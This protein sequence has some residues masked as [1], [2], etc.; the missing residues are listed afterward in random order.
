M[1]ILKKM[2]WK[3]VRR[4]ISA[5]TVI[6]KRQQVFF[7]LGP[8]CL[9][10]NNVNSFPSRPFTTSIK[11]SQVLC[12]GAWWGAAGSHTDV[13][14]FAECG[15]Q[16]ELPVTAPTCRAGGMEVAAVE[17]SRQ[18][19]LSASH[20]LPPENDVT[21][22]SPRV[23]TKPTSLTRRPHTEKEKGQTIMNSV[24]YSQLISTLDQTASLK[25]TLFMTVPAL[26]SRLQLF[27][28]SLPFHL[29]LN[30]IMTQK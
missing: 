8:I 6:F 5:Q 19:R 7:L 2:L 28:P 9:T 13:G 17:I 21:V 30:N 23:I 10:V 4:M 12:S 26:P 24:D 29:P 3:R 16:S 27:L 18:P 14:Q 11:Y 25:T 1:S 15:P 22:P 20:L